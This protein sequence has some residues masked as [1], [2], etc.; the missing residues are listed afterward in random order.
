ML[1]E[2]FIV[3]KRAIGANSFLSMGTHPFAE[4]KK[5]INREN[6]P[7]FRVNFAKAKFPL[8]EAKEVLFYIRTDKA[9]K[10]CKDFCLF[11][12]LFLFERK[13]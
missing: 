3:C 10:S 5:S 2:F 4:S 6:S 9:D 8:G 7:W 13:S 1:Y 12:Q 11:L